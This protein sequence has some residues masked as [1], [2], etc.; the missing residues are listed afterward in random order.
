MNPM[1]GTRGARLGLLL[2]GL[3]EMQVR[4]MVDAALEVAAEGASPRW[5]SCSR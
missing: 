1:L 2:P 3:Y 4:A 5:R